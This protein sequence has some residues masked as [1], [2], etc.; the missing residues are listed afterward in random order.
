M[1]TGLLKYVFL[2]LAVIYFVMPWDLVPDLIGVL[3][4]IEDLLILAYV[5]YRYFGSGASAPEENAAENETQGSQSREQESSGDSAEFDPYA[6]LGVARG[7]T[8]QEILAAYRI[9]AARYHPDKVNH[10]G[11]ELQ[12][13]AHEKMLGIQKAYEMLRV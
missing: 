10:L 12:K 2:A 5:L 7:A 9:E 1:N 11:E 13:M 6:V 8:Q 3:G 4:R